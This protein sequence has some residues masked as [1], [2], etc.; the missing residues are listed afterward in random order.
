MTHTTP[1]DRAVGSGRALVLALPAII[2]GAL[3]VLF[4]AAVMVTGGV[5]YILLL[6]PAVVVV[7]LFALG[8]SVLAVLSLRASRTPV[9]IAAVI[10]GAAALLAS[11]AFG[12]VTGFRI[13]I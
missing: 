12:V 6:S 13:L 8:S 3:A 10:I 4:Y 5:G 7:W 11:L 2:L 1:P 9:T